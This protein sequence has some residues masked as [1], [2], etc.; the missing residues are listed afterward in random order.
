MTTRRGRASTASV[1]H[2]HVGDGL[3][4]RLETFTLD[5]TESGTAPSGD[6]EI[7]LFQYPNW[8]KAQI[9][10]RV[11]IEGGVVK[12]TFPPDERSN[13][14]ADVFLV[15]R[16]GDS[17]FR[18]GERIDVEGLS[19]G[20]SEAD[21]EFELTVDDYVGQVT[22][23]P[24]MVRTETNESIGDGYAA[25][26]G[27]EVATGNVWKIHVDEP[28]ESSGNHI[29]ARLKSFS[30]TDVDDHDLFHVRR[31]PPHEPEIWVNADYREIADVF[32]S[33]G[34]HGFRPRLRDVLLSQ[35]AHPA[36]V[37]LTLWTASELTDEYEWQY[38]WQ[39]GVLTDVCSQMYDV[40]DAELVAERVYEAYHD[41]VG[42]FAGELN[43]V[44]QKHLEPEIALTTLIE[45][46]AP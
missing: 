3:G 22:I 42:R 16:C 20:G 37:E 18:R 44:V 14:P 26:E 17:L 43:S 21:V 8:E 35:V 11:R 9:A 4:L 46:E 15:I 10:G 2:R 34:H 25:Y 40:S 12:K 19:G 27:L 30:D 38:D 24:V 32:E 39:E 29:P 33:G 31:A 45:E 28:T 13:P 6:E 1:P 5:D 41:D 23:Q 36:I 7:E